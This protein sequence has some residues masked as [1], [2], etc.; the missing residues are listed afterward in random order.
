M[1]KSS[2]DLNYL[3]YCMKNILLLIIL[4]FSLSC[5]SQFITVDETYTT[6]ELIEDIL[7]NSPCSG[8]SNYLAVTGTDFGEGNGIAAFNANGSDFPYQ[9]GIILSSGFVSKCARTK[10]TP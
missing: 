8:T 10:P 5:Y 9:E 3:T 1:K 4:L 6:Q 2:L 7:I